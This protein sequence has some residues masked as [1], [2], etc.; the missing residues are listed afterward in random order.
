MPPDATTAA[1][2]DQIGREVADLR[3]L[4]PL[5]PVA[6]YLLPADEVR[7]VLEASF[8]ASGGTQAELDDEAARAQCPRPDQADLQ[9]VHQ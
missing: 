3:G 1:A 2:M 9:P 8:L 7:P 6:G 4:A 5:A